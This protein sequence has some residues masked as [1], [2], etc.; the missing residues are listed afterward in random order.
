VLGSQSGY[1]QN[2]RRINDALTMQ[3]E[4]FSLENEILQG[5]LTKENIDG[6][7]VES[8]S[9]EMTEKVHRYLDR[10]VKYFKL[11]DSVYTAQQSIAPMTCDVSEF[12]TLRKLHQHGHSNWMSGRNRGEDPVKLW[13]LVCASIISVRFDQKKEDPP[14]KLRDLLE[15][16]VDNQDTTEK[17]VTEERWAKRYALLANDSGFRDFM[18]SDENANGWALKLGERVAEELQENASTMLEFLE[19]LYEATETTCGDPLN[20]FRARN[21]QKGFKY[22]LAGYRLLANMYPK[23]YV[24]EAKLNRASQA[25][26]PRISKCK[27]LSDAVWEILPIARRMGRLFASRISTA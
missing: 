19:P 4:L 15:N 13:N 10:R 7:I 21:G 9:P 25:P 3:K 20:D 2:I 27:V 24:D 12:G 6:N 11:L 26:A 17:V 5:S 14:E 23:R 16:N 18:A 22:K 8:I 1:K